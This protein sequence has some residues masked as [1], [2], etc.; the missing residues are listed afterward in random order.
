MRRRSSV[1]S[2]G[3]AGILLISGN[4]SSTPESQNEERERL[5]ARNQRLNAGAFP[6]KWIPVLSQKMGPLIE[7]R[8][9][10]RLLPDRKVL[11][12]TGGCKPRLC[13]RG[14]AFLADKSLFGRRARARVFRL[15]GNGRRPQAVFR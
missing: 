15:I 5:A 8:S 2:A 4:F 1:A 14:R 11:H 9:T 13:Q 7:S 12:P 6:E 10:F 3:A